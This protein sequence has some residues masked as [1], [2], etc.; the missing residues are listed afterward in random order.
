MAKNQAVK[1]VKVEEGN[2]DYI[3]KIKAAYQEALLQMEKIESL[4]EMLNR[5]K[6]NGDFLSETIALKR[7]ASAIWIQMEEM[8]HRI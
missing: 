1:L 5:Q 8:R 2:G 4:L 7:R 3:G 6:E